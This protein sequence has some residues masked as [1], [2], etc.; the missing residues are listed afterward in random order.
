MERPI[1]KCIYCNQSA[2]LLNDYAPFTYW[3]CNKCDVHFWTEQDSDVI[4]HIRLIHE[5]EDEKYYI[6]MY[7]IRDVTEVGYIAPNIPGK[8]LL[9]TK[10]LVKVTPQNAPEFIERLLKLKAF[11]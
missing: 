6:H 3:K 4:N 7:P 9:R 5:R 1:P 10:T 11:L 8:I 2:V